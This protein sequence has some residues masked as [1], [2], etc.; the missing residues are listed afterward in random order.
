MPPVLP[1]LYA[2][3]N[4]A[5]SAC[6][7]HATAYTAPVPLPDN[8][9]VSVSLIRGVAVARVHLSKITEAQVSGLRS[10]LE[11]AAS[12]AAGRL[13]VDLS[14]VE[15]LTSAGLGMFVQVRASCEGGKGRLV[16]C[17]V[18]PIIRDV[19]RITRLDK[20]IPARDDVTAA[21]KDFV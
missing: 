3:P 12:Q 16:L 20:V 2:P 4:R 9:T 18:A 19:L 8:S 10:D 21:L 17:G 14:E 11:Q 1:L 5:Q 7:P 6:A 15:L 13:I